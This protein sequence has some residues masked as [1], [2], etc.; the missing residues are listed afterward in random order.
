MKVFP[1]IY[2][3]MARPPSEKMV[4]KLG[5][6]GGSVDA[7]A[8][9]FK[10][11]FREAHLQLF[12][13]MVKEVWLE[14]QILYE[15]ARRKRNCN[16][17]GSDWIYSYFMKNIVG[18]SQKPVTSGIVFISTPTYFRD[19]FPNFSD[20]DPFVE[21]DYFKYP[22]KQITFRLL[23]RKPPACYPHIKKAN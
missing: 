9:R 20:H 15:G 22:Y 4:S 5:A 14:Q 13:I 16:G 18:I 11:F 3:D 10:N 2:E 21:P 12:D 1:K 19:F 8:I 6:A 23:Q 7:L 17:Y